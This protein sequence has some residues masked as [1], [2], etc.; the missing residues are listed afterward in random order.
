M[1]VDFLHDV[2]QDH[3][4]A[5]QMPEFNKYLVKGLAYHGFSEIRREQLEPKPKKR[6]VAEDTDPTFSWVIDEEVEK[7]LSHFPVNRVSSSKFWYKGYQMQLH[8]SYAEDLSKCSFFLQVLNLKG[9]S[10]VCVSYK[11]KSVLFASWWVQIEERLY[12]AN[13]MSWGKKGVIRNAAQAGYT[14]EVWVKI[15]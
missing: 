3:F 7:K 9:N 1:S 2:V 6:L 4:V 15:K 10:C 8:L 12:K 5:R 11:A 14:I 13:S